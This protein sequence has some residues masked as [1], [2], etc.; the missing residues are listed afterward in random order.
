MDA[1]ETTW[2]DIGVNLTHRRFDADRAAVVARAAA[3]GVRRLVVTGTSLAE[4]AAAA[5]LAAAH[6]GALWSTAGVHPHDARHWNA[7]SAAVLHNLLD[8]PEVV[9]VGECGLDFDR[10][11]SPRPVQR[12]VFAEQIALAVARQRPLFLHCRAAEAEFF[13]QLA[14]HAPAAPGVAPAARVPGAVVHCFTGDAEA[15][16][17]A[18]DLGCMVGITGWVCDERRGTALRDLLPQIPLDRLLLETDAPF[19]TPRDLRPKPKDGRNVPA[20]LPHIGQVV[21]AAM[22]RPVAEVAAATTANALKLFG[23]C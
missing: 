2:V 12:A 7:G 1:P 11:F 23:I 13:E 22:G 20:S 3:A 5:N 19:L 6:P 16:A 18:L 15:L 21:A 4:S 14:P 9:A 8:R 10:D 17:R